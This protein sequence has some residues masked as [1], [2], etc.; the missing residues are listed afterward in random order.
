MNEP[1]KRGRPPKAKLLQ[2]P[3]CPSCGQLEGHYDDCEVGMGVRP[4][5]TRFDAGLMRIVEKH[6]RAEAAQQYALR[7]WNGQSDTVP[8]AERI[9]RVKRALDGQGLSMEGVELP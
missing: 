4:D 9:A 2:A 7:V 8:R 5:P 1:K 3:A 6:A